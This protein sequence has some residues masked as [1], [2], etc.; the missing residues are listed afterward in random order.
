VLRKVF[1]DIPNIDN[2]NSYFACPNHLKVITQTGGYG[3][4]RKI[5]MNLDDSRRGELDLDKS[6]ISGAGFVA[7]HLIPK[8]NDPHYPQDQTFPYPG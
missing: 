4:S 2:P 6:N 3:L 5:I 1:G 8:L 7:K